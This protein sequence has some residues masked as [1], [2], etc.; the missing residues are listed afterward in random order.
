MSF[1]KKPLAVL[2][3]IIIPIL[4]MSQVG[5]GTTTPNAS[6]KLDVTAADKGFLAPRVNLTGTG[7]VATITT[8]ATGLLVYNLQSAG[9]GATA[10][11][12]GFYYYDGIKWQRIINQQP[13]ATVEFGTNANPNTAGT[14]FEGT[15]ASRDFVYV[16]TIDGSQWTYNGSTYVTYTPTPS[17]GWYLTGGT[18]DAGSN[19]SSSVYRTGSVGIGSSTTVNASAM[20]DVNATNKGFLPPR[21]ALTG[22]SDVSTISS[23][24]TGL[25][26]Y[27]T[28][29]AGTTSTS[30]V[31]G[32]YV[33]NGSKWVKLAEESTTTVSSITTIGPNG[34]SATLGNLKVKFSSGNVD[35]ATVSGTFSVCGSMYGI[36]GGGMG[37]T[38][39]DCNTPKALTTTYVNVS[40]GYTY[41][42]D[43][44][45]WHL[46]DNA[47]GTSWRISVLV[48]AG[49]GK[50]TIVIERI[51]QQ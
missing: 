41:A 23:P 31:P 11:T 15:A 7:D 50:N 24:A 10:V 9:S 47:A 6:A 39:Y 32:F 46:Y 34:S 49:Y 30:V 17:T 38:Y 18:K 16:S 21:I 20:L 28:A 8:P 33:Y 37:A 12:P 5:I 2:L 35:L 44:V 45:V 14:T 13:D 48:G 26:I 36:H 1:V 22:T 25:V 4:S 3:N 29:T 19:K 43:L 27:N 51:A 42:G 40:S